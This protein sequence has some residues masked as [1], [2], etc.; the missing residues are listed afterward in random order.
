M[1]TSTI[2]TEKAP[3]A[4][5]PQPKGTRTASKKAKPA[6]KPAQP[7]KVASKP[8]ADRANKKADVMDV[9][10]FVGYIK[11]ELSPPLFHSKTRE[12][13]RRP[14]RHRLSLQFLRT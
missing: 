10:I 12:P 9:L 6:K 5:G 14:H 4:S 2:A 1:N 13:P 11:K 8:K 7:R 3:D